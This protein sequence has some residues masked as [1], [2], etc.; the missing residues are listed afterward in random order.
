MIFNST[1]FLFLFLPVTLLAFYFFG[2]LKKYQ[3]SVYSLIIFS[4]IFYSLS[5]GKIIYIIFFSLIGTY[6]FAYQILNSKN[7]SKFFLWAG[8]FFN[9]LILAYFKYTNFLISNA[10]FLFNIKI[11]SI[12]ILFPIGLSFITF[13]QIIF[14]I[15]IYEKLIDRLILSDYLFYITFFP[16]IISGPVVE[17]KEITKQ[18][19]NPNLF[20]LNKANILTGCFLFLI[21]MTKKV[22][23][24]DNLS[25]WVNAGFASNNLN[26]IEAWLIALS[27]TLQVYFDFSGYCDMAIGTALLFNIGLPINFYSPF[28]ATSIIQFWQRWHM[29]LTKFLT[30]YVF[31]AF[32]RTRSN[33]NLLWV[34]SATIFTM[35]VSGF[36]HGASWLF[37]SFGLLHGFAIVA[38]RIWIS[39]GFKIPSFFGWLFTF[40]FVIFTNVLFRAENWQTAKK[41]Y[42]AM[43]SFPQAFESYKIFSTISGKIFPSSNTLLILT[44]LSLV[45]I[46]A[47][48]S[49]EIIS[50]LKSFSIFKVVLLLLMIYSMFFLGNWDKNSYV[51]FSF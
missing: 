28:K 35:L 25:L 38:N 48:N 18:I 39:Y 2:V 44:F 3:L 46:F 49:Y 43:I 22:V 5:A 33:I 30:T 9:I 36:W 6:F 37:V 10:N 51:Y 50:N 7:Y 45:C 11:E 29:T 32:L 21:G 20:N 17:Y 1:S 41:I 16:K 24:A 34:S 27:F 19:K 26:F 4:C 14:L 42:S 31:T 8:I 13:Q 47:K 15:N 12:K 23:F 40:V